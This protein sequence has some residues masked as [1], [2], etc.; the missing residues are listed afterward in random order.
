VR[1]DSAGTDLEETRRIA[2]AGDVDDD[3]AVDVAVN[4]DHRPLDWRRRDEERLRRGGI[5]RRKE[6]VVAID[7]DDDADDF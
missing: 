2:V 5:T 3:V 1:Q 6:F 7:G 4:A